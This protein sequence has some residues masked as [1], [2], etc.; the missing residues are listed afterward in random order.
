[1]AIT[2]T[3]DLGRLQSQLVPGKKT[4]AMFHASWCP[5]CHAFK[6]I[7]DTYLREGHKFDQILEV[8][9]DENE[10]PIWDSFNVTVVP[11]VILFDGKKELKR[12][13]TN[14]KHIH[15]SDLKSL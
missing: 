14:G 6:P 3:D 11:T 10:N 1:M 5:D 12:F 2:Q 13:E 8:Q 9:I 7:W 4:L 15:M